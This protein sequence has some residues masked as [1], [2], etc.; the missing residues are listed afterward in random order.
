MKYDYLIVG[1]GFA[2]TVLAERIA[3]QLDKKVLVIDKREHFGGNCYDYRDSNGILIHKYGPHIFH[4]NNHKVWEYLSIF[5]DWELY[6]HKVLAVV[7]GLKIPVP[8]NLNSLYMVFPSHY[9]AKLEETL[10]NTYGYG[11]KIPI[12][13][14]KESQNPEL[15]FLA[16]YI[17]KNIFLGYTLKQWELKPEELDHSV[18]SRIPVHISRDDRYFQDIYQGIPK[19]GYSSI[20]EKMINH[21]NIELRLNTEFKSEINNIK[22]DNLIFTGPIDYYFDYVHGQL[23]YRSIRFEL[24]T[25]DLNFFQEVS[26]VNYPN[27]YDF[28]RITEFKHFHRNHNKE[29]SKTVIAKEFSLLHIPGQND[30][31]YPIPKPENEEIHKKYLNEIKELN[32]TVTFAGRQAD[33]KYYNMDQVIAVALQTFEKKIVN[34]L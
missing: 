21:P 20:F 32:G 11:I 8:F 15:S 27:N 28:T 1:A 24:E 18:T 33:Y 29:I 7:E 4:T 13:K 25:F 3:N 2:G 5:T 26:Q 30:P 6:F 31:Y 9:A 14:L 22:F 10:I 23:P 34:S 19:N 16:D 17:Y 12:L